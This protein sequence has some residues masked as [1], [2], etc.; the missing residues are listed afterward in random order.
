M[1]AECEINRCGVLA[2]GR[3]SACGQAM[4]ASHRALTG[5]GTP[6]VDLCVQ[7]Q[8][9]RAAAGA[10]E[11]QQGQDRLQRAYDGV[12]AA[13][14]LLKDS[15]VTQQKIYHATTRTKKAFGGFRETEYP[16]GHVYGWFVG[17]YDWYTGKGGDTFT[18]K[19]FI[20]K[21]S[22][23]AAPRLHDKPIICEMTFSLRFHDHTVGPPTPVGLAPYTNTLERKAEFLEEIA[24]K[25]R[26]LT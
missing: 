7:C 11:S 9:A 8:Q 12:K 21:E 1:P 19:T 3:C 13:V 16:A 10:K 17:E 26:R 2:I 15:A 4:C 22:Q 24:D 20:T 6:V 5:D 14:Q 25:L 23:L 18:A